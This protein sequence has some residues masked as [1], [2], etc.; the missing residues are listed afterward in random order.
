MTLPPVCTY[1]PWKELNAAP[2]IMVD[3]AAK[4]GTLITLSHWPKS[5]TPES[6]K[7][8]SSTDI[9]FK[10]LNA[11]TMHVP[12]GIVTGDHFDEDAS[13]GIFSLLDPEYAL[14]RKD[15]I[16]DVAMAG[17]FATYQ[18]RGAARIAFAILAFSDPSV[19]P[20]GKAIFEKDYD[21]MCADLFREVLPRIRPMVDHPEAFEE[22][23]KP[24]DDFLTR[25]DDALAN[26]AI[27]MQEYPDVSL[28]VVR[29]SDDLRTNADRE[30][31][32][33][34]DLPCHPMTI[35]NATECDRIL[36]LQGNSYV[37]TYRYESW[38]QYV[39]APPM[40]RVD[41]HPLAVQL[42]ESEPDNHSWKFDG[43]E[44]IF[45]RLQPKDS[46]GNRVSSTIEPADLIERIVTFL[47]GAEEAWD[48]YDH[49]GETPGMLAL[50]H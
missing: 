25:S 44:A 30:R 7:A 1:L 21:A 10:Y 41:L 9:V 48:P 5:G 2:N 32:R 14:E 8:D 11:P 6:L 50:P 47:E 16:C 3:G 15:I 17:D 43:V 27:T 22:L 4:D 23:W 28:C 26:G 49:P 36:V 13:M 45:P 18:D 38:V 35:H 24:E 33:R 40:P 31:V 12:A 19:S 42:S 20:L 46:N 37:L 34:G 29:V 39:S